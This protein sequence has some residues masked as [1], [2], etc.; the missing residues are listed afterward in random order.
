MRGLGAG[1]HCPGTLRC[2]SRAWHAQRAHVHTPAR[3]L[4]P[5]L[6]THSPL[7]CTPTPPSAATGTQLTVSEIKL[8]G[9]VVMRFVSGAYEVSGG[10]QGDR[11]DGSPHARLPP[12]AACPAACSTR[13]LP[14]PTPP[15]LPSLQGPFLP[16]YEPVAGAP[17]LD[18]GLQ[19]LDHA[20]ECGRARVRSRACVGLWCVCAPTGALPPRPRS[21]RAIPALKGPPACCPT[22]HPP[23]APSLRTLSGECA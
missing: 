7:P 10:G 11:M 15:P 18:F 5:P 20:G 16:G 17:H 23:P 22:T 14:P 8:Y 1:W 19:R 13:A 4:P 6:H 3:P 9:D 12:P 2:H 21:L